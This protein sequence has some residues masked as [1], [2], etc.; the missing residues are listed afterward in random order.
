MMRKAA[1]PAN[2]ANMRSIGAPCLLFRFKK[3]RMPSRPS[4]ANHNSS[5]ASDGGDPVLQTKAK[6]A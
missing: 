6:P 4:D 3:M 5:A 2:L 1:I